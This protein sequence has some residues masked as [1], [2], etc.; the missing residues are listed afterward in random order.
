MPLVLFW[1][2]CPGSKCAVNKPP[3]IYMGSKAF[4]CK[5]Y[6]GEPIIACLDLVHD[7][8]AFK[9]TWT[10]LLDF[11]SSLVRLDL[12]LKWI[13]RELN[14]CI[15]VPPPR[16]STQR[17]EPCNPSPCGTNARCMERNGAAACLCID[18]YFG[19]PY[20]ECRPEC[21]VHSDC[22]SIKACQE[23]LD[24]EKFSLF[25]EQI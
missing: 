11:D 18:G 17:I 20:T 3:P 24:C 19:D 13:A 10:N 14:E 22:V 9:G 25:V 5:N 16:T 6:F 23:Y 1:G 15:L 2:P 8:H 21:L 12:W 4:L 7:M